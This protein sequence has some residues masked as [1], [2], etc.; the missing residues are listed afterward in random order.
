MIIKREGE[1]ASDIELFLT[2]NSSNPIPIETVDEIR[3]N[4]PN[5][6][7]TG[8]RLITI[9]DYEYFI[10]TNYINDVVDVKC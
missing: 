2:Q 9:Q 5:Y 3:E 6:F 1:E 4:A 10:R 7:K 8:N